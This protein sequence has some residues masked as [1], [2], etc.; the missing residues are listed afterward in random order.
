[1]TPE[2]LGGDSLN[3]ALGIYTGSPVV[4]GAEPFTNADI[5]GNYTGTL[6]VTSTLL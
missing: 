2:E 1:V 4:A 5:P 6:T 3:I